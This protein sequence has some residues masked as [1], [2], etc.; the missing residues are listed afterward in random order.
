MNKITINGAALELDLLDADVMDRY[1]K[2]LD[3]T[4]SAIQDIQTEAGADMPG[5]QVAD[6][7]REQCR[8]VQDFTDKVFGAGTAQKCFPRPGHLGDHLEAFTKIC[9]LADA[10]V[11]QAKDIANRYSGERLMNRQQRRLQEQGARMNPAALSAR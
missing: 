11:G 5:L 10:A 2:A 6:A 1:Q 9:S 7:M 3:E 4:V 8:L